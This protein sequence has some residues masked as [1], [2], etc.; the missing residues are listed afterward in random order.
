M[1]VRFSLS[2]LVKPPASFMSRPCRM[3]SFP[4][5]TINGAKSDSADRSRDTN[6]YGT[7]TTRRNF[8]A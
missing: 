5:D 7:C 3:F 8:A 1:T 2:V 6:L 4:C